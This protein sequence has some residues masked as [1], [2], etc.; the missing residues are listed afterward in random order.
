MNWIYPA[1]IEELK[2]KCHAF[3]RK[4]ISVTEIQSHIYEAEQKIVALDEK[5]L[6][7]LLFNAEN[8]IELSLYTLDSDQVFPKVKII[9]EEILGK[10]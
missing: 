5:W 1:V 4:E 7:E 8:E 2:K 10:I 9:I 3:L 6:R